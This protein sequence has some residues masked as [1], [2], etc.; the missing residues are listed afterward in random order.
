MEKMGQ[1]KKRAAKWKTMQK[2]NV[3]PNC[4]SS[5]P[6]LCLSFS[7]AFELG[8]TLPRH[9]T[10]HSEFVNPGDSHVPVLPVRF[11]DPLTIQ[12]EAQALTSASKAAVQF[13]LAMV[14]LVKLS[15]LLEKFTTA[16]SDI[17]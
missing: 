12:T 5:S 13:A 6:L 1:K 8:S 10:V 3:V 11:D 15:Q 9:W 14:R 16:E 2:T 4:A 17:T 7:D